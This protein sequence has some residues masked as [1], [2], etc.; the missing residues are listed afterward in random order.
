M[1]CFPSFPQKRE[2]SNFH[3][4]PH[5]HTDSIS[6]SPWGVASGAIAGHLVATSL[7]ILGGGF[8]ANYIS[9]KLVSQ[10]FCFSRIC[11]KQLYFEFLA[12][13]SWFY[14]RLATWVVSYS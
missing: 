5:C 2:I 4:F 7:A 9:E 6:Q 8:L 1:I 10:G 14:N 3:L 12:S 11:S 13:L